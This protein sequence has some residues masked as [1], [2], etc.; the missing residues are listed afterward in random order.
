[1]QPIIYIFFNR[2]DKVE[3]SFEAI[4]RQKP[5]MLYL[6]TDGPR[7]Y[8]DHDKINN[9]YCISIIKS[10]LNWPCQV[11]WINSDWNLGCGR[12]ISSCL[13]Y[14]FKKEIAAIIIEDDCICTD[15][16]FSF[17]SDALVR[18]ADD[19]TI[20]HISG[21][22]FT[23][24]I[25]PDFGIFSPYKTR[26]AEMWGWGTW[27]RAW[28]NYS[29]NL[30]LSDFSTSNDKYKNLTCKWPLRESLMHK[31]FCSG[32]GLIDTWDFQWIH[33]V[34]TS[35]CYAIAPPYSLV[36]NIGMDEDATHTLKFR[37]YSAFSANAG[38]RSTIAMPDQLSYL[39][40]ID[41]VH[42]QRRFPCRFR[43]AVR[44]YLLRKLGINRI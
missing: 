26:I 25:L 37:D 4:A 31:A 8:H 44:Y 15:E 11:E 40:E 1:M 30:N 27:A 35:D 33:S 13:D 34:I 16:F 7:T 9:E 19:P 38:D 22:C 41:T 36:T 32:I 5:A 2:P 21:S 42:L 28:K 23:A 39:K 18:Y 14:V 29:F 6:C 10:L 3:K 17:V 24:D 12:R 43:A 20:N